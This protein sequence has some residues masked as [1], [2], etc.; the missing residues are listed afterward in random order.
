MENFKNIKDVK[1]LS[2]SADWNKSSG[3]HYAI[4]KADTAQSSEGIEKY[5]K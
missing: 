2:F 1:L 5:S 4:K 3:N